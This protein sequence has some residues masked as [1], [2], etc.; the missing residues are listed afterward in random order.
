MSIKRIATLSIAI[1]TAF[2]FVVVPATA[3]FADSAENEVCAG[4]STG[5]SS[6]NCSSTSGPS[7]S[8]I[9]ATV[10]NIFSAI[11]GVVAVIM[12]IYGGFQMA[13][14]GDDPGKIKTGRTIIMYALV[15][16]GVV[17]FAQAFV[18]FVLH[19]VGGLQ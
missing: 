4:V 13:I 15:G 18:Q 10:I 3:V 6:S 17:A 5:S 2:C 12:M 9:F 14:G 16:L 8:D 11:I 19:R 7:V 1:F